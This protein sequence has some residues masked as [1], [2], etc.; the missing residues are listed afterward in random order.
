MKDYSK[1]DK[2][3]LEKIKLQKEVEVLGQSFFKRNF[4]SIVALIIGVLSLSIG[5]YT[6][7]FDVKRESLKLEKEN[8]ERD[9]KDFKDEKVAL[10][11]ETKHLKST[12]DSLSFIIS[13]TQKKADSIQ[14]KMYVD[15][16]ALAALKT[17]YT[18]LNDRYTKLK[19]LADQPLLSITEDFVPTDLPPGIVLK[20]QVQV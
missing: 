14:Q 6:G 11:N 18:N 5:I 15:S 12:T 1:Y 17:T 2:T 4:G 3:Q 7:L 8:L 20:M 10:Q 9:V 19:N 13:K 16:L